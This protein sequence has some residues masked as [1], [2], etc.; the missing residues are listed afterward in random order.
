MQRDWADG[1]TAQRTAQSGSEHIVQQFGRSV[2]DQCRGAVVLLG[3]ALLH[4]RRRT[5]L[6]LPCS[7]ARED[8]NHCALLSALMRSESASGGCTITIGACRARPP[9][10][11]PTVGTNTTQNHK[12]TSARHRHNRLGLNR[13]GG[14][15]GGSCAS[16][17]CCDGLQD[18]VGRCRLSTAQCVAVQ[19]LTL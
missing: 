7:A 14:A 16:T 3:L 1:R 5:S 4:V 15:A 9:S 19:A 6:A 8:P 17:V 18:W 2:T 10:A 13:R 11:L 12:H